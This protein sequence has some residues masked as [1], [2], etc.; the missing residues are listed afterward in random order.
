MVVPFGTTKRTTPSDAATA[1][2]ADP[3]VVLTVT[4]EPVSLAS[5]MNSS[6]TPAGPR[7]RNS[8]ITMAWAGAATTAKAS[9][10][11]ARTRLSMG[12]AA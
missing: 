3:S 5:S 6:L 11:S 2:P 7:M 9:A 10:A 1:Q 12:R 8:L 4:G